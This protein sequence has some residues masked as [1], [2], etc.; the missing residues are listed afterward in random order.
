ME[1][2]RLKEWSAPSNYMGTEYKGFY[3]FP[4]VIQS[5]HD[6]KRNK[7]LFARYFRRI[8]GEQYDESKVYDEEDPNV[9]CLVAA[10]GHWMIGQVEV[11]FIRNPDTVEGHV[12]KGKA[13]EAIHAAQQILDEINLDIRHWRYLWDKDNN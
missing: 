1:L 5:E 7:K 2:M 4:V 12:L 8:S 6:G 10:L 3:F 9:I 13:Y 11:I